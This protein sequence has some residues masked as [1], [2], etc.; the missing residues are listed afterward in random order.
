VRGASGRAGQSL[1]LEANASSLPPT[2]EPMRPVTVSDLWG[3]CGWAH[4][5]VRYGWGDQ[6]CNLGSTRRT[7]K[8]FCLTF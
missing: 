8:H 1:G 2:G 7:D 4:V 3:G 6:V 5:S